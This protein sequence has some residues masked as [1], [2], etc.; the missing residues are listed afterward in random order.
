MHMDGTASSI[1]LHRIAIKPNI[2]RGTPHNTPQE[3]YAIFW[4]TFAEQY[5]FFDL[6][7]VNWDATDKK[8]RPQVSAD[9]KPDELFQILRK[10]IEPLQDSHTGLEAPNIGAEFDGWMA[11]RSEPS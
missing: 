2:C 11:Q 4:Q 1:V 6:H 10:M 3:N 5:A 9:T 7:K 8:S